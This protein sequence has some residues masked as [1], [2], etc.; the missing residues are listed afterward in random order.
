MYTIDAEFKKRKWFTIVK[1][2][3]GFRYNPD[4]MLSEY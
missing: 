2:K 4:E 3:Y 1:S